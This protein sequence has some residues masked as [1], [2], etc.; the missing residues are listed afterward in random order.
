MRFAYGF[1]VDRS[2]YVQ[3]L[4]MLGVRWS[5]NNSVMEWF[6]FYLLG[7][8]FYFAF[9]DQ[10]NVMTINIYGNIGLALVKAGIAADDCTQ[11]FKEF[12][13]EYNGIKQRYHPLV[14]FFM[15]LFAR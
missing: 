6:E 1:G 9:D 4:I 15:N 8:R 7:F 12:A 10:E 13:A 5:Y 11:S 2:D 3:D 14:W